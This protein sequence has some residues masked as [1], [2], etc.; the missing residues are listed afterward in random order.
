MRVLHVIARLNVGGTARYITRLA[1]EL[2]KQKIETFIA[3]GFVQGSEQ[4]DPS[5]K[6]LKVIRIRSLGRQINPI[7]DHFAFKQLL[8]VVNEVKPDI[9]HTHTFKAGYIGRIK[10]RE[11]NKAAG[12]Q[13]KFVHTFHGHLFDDPE[14][15]GL[16]SLI[17]TSFERRFAMRTDAIITVGAQV[18]KELLERE[19]GQPEQF[20]NIPPG[21]EPLKLP[22]AKPRTKIT[23]G[24][25]ARVTGVK[26]PLRALEIAKLF[27]DAQFLIAGGGDL[28]NQVRAQAPKNTKVLGWTDAAKLFAAS[29]IILSTSENEGMPIALIEAQLAS[30]PVV[31]TNVGGVAEVVLNNKTGFVTKKNTQELAKALEKLIASKSLRTTQGKAAKAHATKAFSVEKMISAHVSLYKKLSK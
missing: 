31:A 4:E 18:A 14:F 20:T 5:A 3:T 25:I 15:S 23:I 22:K 16:K 21:V 28:L 7:K 10:T 9:L 6:N 29:D 11:I 27:P 13:V 17:I 1:E 26:N 30:K 2:P 24:W 8:K 19:I 12:K